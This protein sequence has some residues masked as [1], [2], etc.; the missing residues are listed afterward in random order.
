LSE[1]RDWSSCE[2]VDAAGDPPPD[3]VNVSGAS[4][5][6]PERYKKSKS[7]VVSRRWAVQNDQWSD[8]A[9]F[10]SNATDANSYVT[11]SLADGG[12]GGV[13]YQL[14]ECYPH[15]TYPIDSC[16]SLNRSCTDRT[17]IS[18]SGNKLS[19]LDDVMWFQCKLVVGSTLIARFGRTRH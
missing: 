10:A 16:H 18:V 2:A 9:Y 5:A 15:E 1:T 8:T 3:G 13:N 14:A 11:K 4:G 19:G 17:S 12:G 7:R 6:T